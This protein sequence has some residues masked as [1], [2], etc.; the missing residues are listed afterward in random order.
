MNNENFSVGD[1]VSNKHWQGHFLIIQYEEQE[2]LVVCLDLK[3]GENQV[4]SVEVF[5]NKNYKVS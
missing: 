2:D 1:I 3:Y 5:K 4:W